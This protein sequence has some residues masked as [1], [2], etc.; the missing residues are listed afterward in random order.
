MKVTNSLNCNDLVNVKFTEGAAPARPSAGGSSVRGRG[1]HRGTRSAAAITGVQC[2]LDLPCDRTN[3]R[4][5]VFSHPFHLP[6]ID[7]LLIRLKFI[8]K[9]FKFSV[10][11][12][13]KIWH[14]P[15]HWRWLCDVCRTLQVNN[16][17][18]VC[19]P[20]RNLHSNDFVISWLHCTVTFTPNYVNLFL[21]GFSFR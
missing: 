1:S 5:L 19:E 11:E 7:S 12:F 8:L 13:L 4:F 2:E 3:D 17:E 15:K 21:I 10:L 20:E 14:S 18:C 9:K 16:F 6:Q